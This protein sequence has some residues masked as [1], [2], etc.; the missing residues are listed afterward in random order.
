[1]AVPAVQRQAGCLTYKSL[2]LYNT[3]C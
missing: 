2:I 1:M 3:D